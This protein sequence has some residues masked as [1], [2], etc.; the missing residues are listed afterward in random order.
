LSQELVFLSYRTNNR[1]API[2]I[3]SEFDA[4]KSEFSSSDK[5]DIE[6]YDLS[7]NN[8]NQL[9]MKCDIYSSDWDSFVWVFEDGEKTKNK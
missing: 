1:L 3:L 5:S 8:V 4:L 2:K 9:A 7:I 6:C